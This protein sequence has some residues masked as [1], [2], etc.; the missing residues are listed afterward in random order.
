M[1]IIE[2]D[3]STVWKF[4]VE[5]ELDYCSL[6]NEGYTEVGDRVTSIVNPFLEGTLASFGNDNIELFSRTDFFNKL[7]RIE[8]KILFDKTNIKIVAT[9]KSHIDFSL[10]LEKL[11]NFCKENSY[12]C[13]LQKEEMY[14]TIIIEETQDNFSKTGASLKKHPENNGKLFLFCYCFD[15]NKI[16]ISF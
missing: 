6:Y 16:K 9:D 15:H 2:W 12:V 7:P 11:Q 4:I 1:P 14:E 10:L 5:C 13:S 8:G 3:Y